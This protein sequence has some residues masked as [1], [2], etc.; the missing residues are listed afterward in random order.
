M[1]AFRKRKVSSQFPTSYDSSD[2]GRM[3]VTT[4]SAQKRGKDDPPTIVVE[5]KDFNVSDY[6]EEIDMPLDKDYKLE[7]MLR[8]GIVPEEVPVSGILDSS[9][10]LDLSN[11]GVGDAIFDKLSSQVPNEPSKPVS[12]PAPGNTPSE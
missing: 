2:F 5:V 4:S 12:E 11:S 1:N 6:S 8:N 9:D 3:A 7:T 10:P